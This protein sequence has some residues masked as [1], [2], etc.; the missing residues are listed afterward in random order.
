MS[1][2]KIFDI[3]IVSAYPEEKELLL[4]DIFIKIN[5]V[6]KS[7][8]D[9]YDFIVKCSLSDY[10]EIEDKVDRKTQQITKHFNLN[11][12]NYTC[13]NFYLAELLKNLRKDKELLNLLEK[14]KPNDE[15]EQTVLNFYLGI[16]NYNQGKY[17]DALGYH[18]KALRLKEITLG[19]DH[20]YTALNNECI[21]AVY[22]KL[23]EYQTAL[24]YYNKVIRI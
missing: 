1:S 12:K 18:L 20:P 23:G 15:V 22:A 19:K 2:E 5:Y 7:K 21:G 4:Y 6:E 24:E 14:I 9:N 8:D 3:Q 17:K 11:D 10:S 16:A 13:D